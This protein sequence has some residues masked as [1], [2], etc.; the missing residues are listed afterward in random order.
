MQA[1]FVLVALTILASFG[2]TQ[3]MP[4]APACGVFKIKP[5]DESRIVN[6][7]AAIPHSRPYQLLLVG[8]FDNGTAKFYC[9]A[10]LVK[11]THAL[12]AAHCV[13]GNAAKNIRLF[14]GVHNFSAN[15]LK[16]ENGIPAR[17]FY[18][19][20]SYNDKSLVNDVAVVR[21]QVPVTID[22]EKTGLICL[23]EKSTPACASGN[24]VV[25]KILFIFLL[26]CKKKFI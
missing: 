16:P 2:Q 22:Q 7:E 25:G 23:P 24:P 13:V 21:L 8:F 19:H 1:I 18:S 5:K 6:G 26:K 14:P 12:T 3:D 15:L 9:G 17:E 10:S 20:E 4:K 11:P